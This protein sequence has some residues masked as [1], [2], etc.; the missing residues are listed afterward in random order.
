MAD[1]AYSSDDYK[2][3]LNAVSPLAEQ[4]QAKYIEQLKTPAGVW[5][6][7]NFKRIVAHETAMLKPAH[8]KERQALEDKFTSLGWDP[9]QNARY[10][11]ALLEQLTQ[12]EKTITDSIEVPLLLEKM[13]S[14]DES[15]RAFLE[16][17]GQYGIALQN[18]YETSRAG[19]FNEYEFDA[20]L[21]EEQRQ[22]NANLTEEQR[23]YNTNL[24]EEQRQYNIVQSGYMRRLSCS[25]SDWW[26]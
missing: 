4:T 18:A 2:K 21:T 10:P 9:Q 24:T 13:R 14:Q 16:Q 15:Q 12:H 8:D 19:R 6:D 7:D 1:F 26:C 17:S 20:N 22:Y 25:G 3:Y 5:D 23:Q 11:K